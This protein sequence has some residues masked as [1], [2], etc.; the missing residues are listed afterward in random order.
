MKD[1]HAT[2]EKIVINNK[3]GDS[4]QLQDFDN[5]IEQYAS[6][7]LS[8]IPKLQLPIDT[9]QVQDAAIE[10]VPVVTVTNPEQ[11]SPSVEESKDVVDDEDNEFTELPNG[12]Q[13]F[14]EVKQT[15]VDENEQKGN[16]DE[17]LRKEKGNQ[18]ADGEME[19]INANG[20]EATADDE[21]VILMILM[22]L[23]R[24]LRRMIE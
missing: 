23:K 15:N 12:V 18:N 14:R 13:Y 2:L 19:N 6:Q 20:E 4:T 8:P 16:T 21:I 10:T 24:A 3:D 17:N 22:R 7:T 1:Y 11:I 9:S 5:I